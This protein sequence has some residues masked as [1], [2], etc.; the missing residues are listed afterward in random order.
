MG[1]AAGDVSITSSSFSQVIGNVTITATTSTGAAAAS[2]YTFFTYGGAA[3]IEGLPGPEF[4]INCAAGLK[5]IV[6]VAST[7]SP[8]NSTQF[9][10]YVGTYPGG[11]VQQNSGT[12]FGSPFTFVVPLTNNIGVTRASTNPGSNIVGLAIQDS[13]AL[14][15]SGVGGSFTAGGPGNVLGTWANP[16]PLGVGDATRPLIV[17]PQNNQIYTL[18]LKQAFYPSLIG[19]TAGLALD[20][21]TGYWIVDTGGATRFSRSRARLRARRTKWEA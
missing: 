4:I 16:A 3:S 1:P 20:T 2:Y 6:N 8:T 19:T 18:S 11:E 12:N 21:T 9:V 13:A 10:T 15:A 5:P 7:G 17:R 14:Y